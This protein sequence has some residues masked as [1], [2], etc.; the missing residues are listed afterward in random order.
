MLENVRNILICEQKSSEKLTKKLKAKIQKSEV[1]INNYPKKELLKKLVEKV[2]EPIP[3]E[4]MEV[5][6]RLIMLYSM[7]DTWPD[8]TSKTS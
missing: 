2:K 6:E 3:K 7:T 8:I 1:S 4:D 5:A